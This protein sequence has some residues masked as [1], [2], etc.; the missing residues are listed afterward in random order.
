[1]NKYGFILWLLAL[2]SQLS[3]LSFSQGIFYAQPGQKVEVRLELGL[4][5]EFALQKR[6][7]FWLEHPFVSGKILEL[8]PSGQSWTQD[9]AH[10]LQT[11]EPLV[12]KLS[13]PA[14]AKTGSYPIKI[15]AL[16]FAC[17]KAL[18]VCQKHELT[19]TGQVLVGKTGQ[20][21]VLKLELPTTAF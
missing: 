3:A 2:S 5:P 16:V 14:T 17:N 13:V 19:A 15:R 21:Q 1:M 4:P 20:A 18:G 8:K 12:W 10:Y 6:T 9:P 11:L 7:Q